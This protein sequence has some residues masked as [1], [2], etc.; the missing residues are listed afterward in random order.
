MKKKAKKAPSK[1]RNPTVKPKAKTKLTLSQ[2]QDSLERAYDT[3]NELKQR[4]RV[5]EVNDVPRN[6]Q[7]DRVHERV[8]GLEAVVNVTREAV[9]ILQF[10]VREQDTLVTKRLTAVEATANKTSLE[11]RSHIVVLQEAVAGITEWS[12][13]LGEKDSATAMKIDGIGNLLKDLQRRVEGHEQRLIQVEECLPSDA[14]T[15]HLEDLRTIL[16][17]RGNDA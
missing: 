2:Q 6:K 8:T 3:I 5:L 1:K 17:L 13:C 15:K 14:Q 12:K 9:S 10:A 7:F 16:E 4:V 11:L